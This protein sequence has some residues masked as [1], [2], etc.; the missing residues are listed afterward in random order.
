[1]RRLL[2]LLLIAALTLPAT[3]GA[4]ARRTGAQATEPMKVR[5]PITDNGFNDQPTDF[6]VTVP[7]GQLIELT[8][9]WEQQIHVNDE[10]IMIL[11]GYNL[12]WP[13]IDVNNRE[14]SLRFVAEKAGSFRLK[15]DLECEIHDLLKDG[16]L[17]VTEPGTGA[18]GGPDTRPETQLAL[19]AP[20][21]A[22]LGNKVAFSIAA[23]DTTGAPIAGAKLQLVEVT[24]FY[25]LDPQEVDVARAVTA[26]DG[27]AT[28]EYIARRTGT[29]TLKAIF[30]G[31]SQH[32]PASLDVQLDVGDGP[33]LYVVHPPTGIPGV[34]RFFV[35]GIIIAVWGTMFIVAMHV[36]G[37]VRA[38][39]TEG[40][41]EEDGSV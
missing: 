4:G 30:P 7:Q 10:H 26:A 24:G 11:E 5:I 39:R 29:R 14:A 21:G 3:L 18:A 19:T 36:V 33:S 6:T 37:I 27:T 23:G 34:N 12:E 16:K 1:M 22:S 25:G 13:Q 32:A 41:G 9:V 31:D 40:S 28:L 35:S 38:G 8:F 2:L 17:L 20:V 15:C